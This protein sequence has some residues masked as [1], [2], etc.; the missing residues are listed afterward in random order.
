LLDI[1]GKELFVSLEIPLIKLKDFYELSDENTLKYI[2]VIYEKFTELLNQTIKLFDSYNLICIQLN[3]L[4]NPK[5]I[6]I[7][8]VHVDS[9]TEDDDIKLFSI[10]L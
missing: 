5:F 10:R 6:S 9:E 3:N 8:S 4:I 1:F 7:K 2:I